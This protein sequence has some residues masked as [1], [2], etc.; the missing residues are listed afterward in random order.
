ML[1]NMTDREKEI[2]DLISDD[3]SVTVAELGRHLGVSAVTVRTSL[4]TLAKKGY[5]LRTWGGAFPTFHPD[6]ME[7]QRD[8]VEEKNRI[9]KAAAPKK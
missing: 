7:H 9:A 4:N 3:P 2:L 6:M 5:I 8:R 1:A